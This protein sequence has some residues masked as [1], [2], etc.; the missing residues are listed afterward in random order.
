MSSAKSSI[1]IKPI[2]FDLAKRTV[3]EFAVERNVPTQTYP[4]AVSQLPPQQNREGDAPKVIAKPMPAPARKLTVV[5]PDYVIDAVLTR[6]L[7]SKPKTTARFVVLQAFK[8][9]GID[10]REVDMV[11]DGRRHPAS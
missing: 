11:P 10:V 7:Q 5:L 4:Q 3:D 1:P 8:A 2:D 9:I 6:A